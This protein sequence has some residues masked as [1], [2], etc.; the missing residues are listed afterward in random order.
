MSQRLSKHQDK[1]ARMQVMFALQNLWHPAGKEMH[2]KNH[3]IY[4]QCTVNISITLNNMYDLTIWEN[5]RELTHTTTKT[6]T[7]LQNVSQTELHVEKTAES[8][9][10]QQPQ[11]QPHFKMSHKRNY[12]LITSQQKQM[13]SK[14]LFHFISQ[15]MYRIYSH[16][17]RKTKDKIMPQKLGGGD[18]SPGLYTSMPPRSLTLAVLECYNCSL[19][20]TV[21]LSTA[22]R[23]PPSPALLLQ[24]DQ[25]VTWCLLL[26]RAV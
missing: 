17:S 23:P 24:V 3:S 2:K 13:S 14:L 12:T 26:Q 21:S 10:I 7:T 16:I 11:Q 15:M 5:S 4:T 25:C 6:T 22:R 19:K 9:L 20:T 8:W 18:L 1:P